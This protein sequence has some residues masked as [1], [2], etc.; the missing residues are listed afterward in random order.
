MT[1]ISFTLLLLYQE[2]LGNRGKLSNFLINKKHAYYLNN[3][4]RTVI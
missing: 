1:L 3:T 2:R 4:S